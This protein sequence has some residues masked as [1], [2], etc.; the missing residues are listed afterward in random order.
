[1]SR[2]I[3]LPHDLTR[4]W[5]A[6]TAHLFRKRGGEMEKITYTCDFCKEEQPETRPQKIMLYL[7]YVP[8]HKKSLLEGHICKPCRGRLGLEPAEWAWDK[9]NYALSK[10]EEPTTAEKL[11]S[12]I[13]DLVREAVDN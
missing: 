5:G 2:A 12:I 13:Y 4:C 6:G 9:K 8:T 7:D 1:M 11:E 3:T 10:L